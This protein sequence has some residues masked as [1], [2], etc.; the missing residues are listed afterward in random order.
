[1]APPSKPPGETP[2]RRR[3][4][5]KRPP[6]EGKISQPL[7]PS[8]TS[9]AAP[10]DKL[11]RE[12]KLALAE[13]IELEP[14]PDLLRPIWRRGR[15]SKLSP[16]ITRRLVTALASGIHL[17]T[18][19][20]LNSIARQSVSNWMEQGRKDIEAGNGETAHALF[21]DAISR[22][23]AD[24]EASLVRAVTMAVAGVIPERPGYYPPDPKA[25]IA[26]LQV[27]YRDRYRKQMQF[28]LAGVPDKPL[29]FQAINVYIPSEDPEPKPAPIEV[30]AEIVPPALPPKAN[31]RNGSGGP[32][33]S[34]GSHR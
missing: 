9:P 22:A 32:N 18:A 7:P 12:A 24:A 14:R 29:T 4:I 11:R 26:F 13:R 17:E 2:K 16:E 28:D 27:R 21:L 20:D 23:M 3:D 6:R 33:G 19:C 25:G 1:M 15:P 5:P 10:R 34:G 8:V 30:D 31:G